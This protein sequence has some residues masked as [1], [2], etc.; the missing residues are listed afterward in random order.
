MHGDP[1]ALEV[2]VIDLAPWRQGRGGQRL[3]V[4]RSFGEAMSRSGFAAIVNHGVP[5]SLEAR[6]YALAHAFFALPM[7]E[8]VR[9]T[10]PEQT[11]ARG[12]L[13]LGIESVAA[14]LAG[15][16]PPD[17]CEA[18]VFAS[19][20]R[21]RAGLGRPNLW[22]GR[23]PGLAAAVNE[24]FDAMLR[25]GRELM[26]ISA[27]ALSLPEHWFDAAY[28]TPS[29]TLRYV[30][31]PEQPAPPAEGQMRYGAHHDYGGLT[32][33]RQD[34]V[35]GLQICDR[36][37][38]WHDVAPVPG[39]FVI[40][41]GDLMSRWTNG[42]WRSTLHRVVN[43]PPDA[44]GRRRLSMVAFTGPAPQ[45]EVAV[46]PSCVSP[47][48]PPRYGPVVAQDYVRRKLEASMGERGAA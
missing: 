10:A 31:Y 21:E 20:Q 28:E 22:P 41:V 36:E 25:L 34:E 26:R 45:T 12:Y 38:R 2:P 23:P 29:L 9:H 44:R 40:N 30:C 15:P 19:L 3:D 33:L 47:G 8:K 18:L 27:V 6:M 7:Q 24:W 48:R 5:A 39:S 43:P 35:G 17:L 11:K 13:P 16:T 4:A 46:L 37:G 32:L 42:L 1:Q 14:T